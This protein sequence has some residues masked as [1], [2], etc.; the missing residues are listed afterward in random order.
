M[1]I[2]SMMIGLAVGSYITWRTVVPLPEADPCGF[3]PNCAVPSRPIPSSDLAREGLRIALYDPAVEPES[4]G[5]YATWRPPAEPALGREAVRADSSGFRV[6]RFG[7]AGAQGLCL[8]LD[9]ER[10][11]CVALI[12]A[13]DELRATEHP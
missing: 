13:N 7:Q 2:A 5:A 12:H 8:A 10:R 3:D 4:D 6:T 1:R 11:R 9:G